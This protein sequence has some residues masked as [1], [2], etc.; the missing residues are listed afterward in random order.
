MLCVRCVSLGYCP[1]RWSHLVRDDELSEPLFL[2]DFKLFVTRYAFRTRLTPDQWLDHLTG[3]YRD[4][5]GWLRNQC[6]EEVFLDMTV[7]EVPHIRE[8]FRDFVRPVP[9]GVRPRIKAS[10]KE[11]V[12]AFTTIMRAHFPEE[13][14]MWGVRA[15]NDN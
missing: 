4:Y 8:W 6:G 2:I 13:A 3:L 15:A 14:M 5:P 12:R 1:S 9:V 11:R 10:A 7:F